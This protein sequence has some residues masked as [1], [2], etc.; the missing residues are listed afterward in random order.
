MVDT[1]DSDELADCD[2]VPVGDGVGG[3]VIVLDVV[4]ESGL[5]NVEVEAG[6]RV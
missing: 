5:V 4:N 3:G 2:A 1:F 6:V